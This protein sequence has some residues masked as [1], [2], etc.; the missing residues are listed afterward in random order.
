[1]EITFRDIMQLTLITIEF[2]V[3]FLYPITFTRYFKGLPTINE[4]IF[5]LQVKKLSQT[6][7]CDNFLMTLS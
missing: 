5:T 6:Q 7:F 1:V 2:T 4:I 3:F